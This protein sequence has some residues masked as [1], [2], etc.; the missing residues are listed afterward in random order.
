MI[1]IKYPVSLN[2]IRRLKASDIVSFTGKI[3]LIGETAFKR[4]IN[5]ERA[6][7]LVPD[8]IKGEL[9]CFGS[10]EQNSVKGI[11]A[12][13]CEPFLEKAFLYGATSI[14]A[15]DSK[16]DDAFFKRFGRVLF[17]P[18]SEIKP[19]SQR[20]VAHVD[21]GQEAVHEIEVSRLVM[22]VVIDSRGNKTALEVEA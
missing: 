5:Y 7:G 22:R 6:E 12:K 3:V 17:V 18:E 16:F 8:F 14:I 4:I 2:I 11:P 15:F 13:N 21:L 1:F 9:V 19:L 20:T 10:I